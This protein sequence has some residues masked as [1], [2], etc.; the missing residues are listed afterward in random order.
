MD[1][2]QRRVTWMNYGRKCCRKGE[3]CRGSR[4][5]GPCGCV[6]IIVRMGRY[7]LVG[8]DSVVTFVV[9][10]VG[11]DLGATVGQGYPVLPRSRPLVLRLLVGEAVPGLVVVDAV[12]EQVAPRGDL[13]GGTDPTVIKVTVLYRRQLSS[14]DSLA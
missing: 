14:K 1:G 8:D 3:S 2:S 7:A 9:G 12:R 13:W 4:W 10:R 11:D 6:C 5:K